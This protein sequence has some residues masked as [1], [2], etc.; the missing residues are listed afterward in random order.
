MVEIPPPRLVFS[1][2]PS[3]QQNEGN[4]KRVK[5]LPF[6]RFRNGNLFVSRLRRDVPANMTNGI[7]IKAKV[8]EVAHVLAQTIETLSEGW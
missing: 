3:V 6:H 2:M 5:R 7:S 4:Y 8:D 1:K